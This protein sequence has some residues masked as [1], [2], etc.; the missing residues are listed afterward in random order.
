MSQPVSV[1]VSS[2]YQIVVP[3]TAR[4]RLS[5]RSGD[6]LLVDIQ[7]GLLILLPQPED[8]T[9]HLAGLHRE[10]WADLDPAAYLQE[11]QDAWDASEST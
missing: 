2:R 4:E 5:I 8:Y 7:D 9:A 3:S 6:H 1:K 11:E 10:V